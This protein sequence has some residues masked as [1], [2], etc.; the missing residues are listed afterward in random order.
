MKNE[1]QSGA[2]GDAGVNYQIGDTIVHWTHGLGTIV[3]I[4]Q[5]DIAGVTE[6]YY[7]VDVQLLKLWVPLAEANAGSLRFPT[8]RIQ[9]NALF[10]IL[11]LPGDHLPDHQYKRKFYLRERMQKR[12]LGDLCH[13]IRDLTDRSRLHPLNQNDSAVLY[14]A[15]EHLLDEWVL[16]L[17][18]ER[19]DALRALEELLGRSL[20][21]P[22][23]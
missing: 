5:R 13:V 9:F 18:V 8:E 17:R 15:E 21:E 10:D 14:R 19:N 23:A 11:R 2:F 1:I 7:V 16:S 3:A 12:S 22:I 6:Q 20:T 4:E